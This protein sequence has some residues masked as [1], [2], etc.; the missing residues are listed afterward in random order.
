[1]NLKQCKSYCNYLI[2]GLCSDDLAYRLQNVIP[3][4]NFETRKDNLLKSEFVDE[5][6]EVSW[7]NVSRKKCFE[8]L[9]F[10]VCFIGSE[11]GIQ[12][13]EDLAYF[14]T[15]G[16][17][18]VSLQSERFSLST[19][20][21]EFCLELAK[22]D[23]DIVLWGTGTYF[24]AY[25]RELGNKY[26]PAYAV[27]SNSDRWNTMKEGIPIY[28]P[29]KLTEKTSR[30][31]FVIIC[32]KNYV[33]IRQ[34]LLEIGRIDYRTLFFNNDISLMDEYIVMLEEEKAYMQEAHR[35]LMILLKEFDRVCRKYNLKYFM[36][37]GSLIGA[38]RHRALIPWDDDVDVAMFRKD[39]DSLLRH[40]HEEWD[41]REFEYVNY[42]ELGDNLF[43]DFM[44]RLVYK[45]ISL[46]NDIYAKSEPKLRKDLINKLN[47]DIYVLDNASDNI[48]YHN[49]QMLKIRALYG[50]A[51]GHRVIFD[52]SN[53]NG[54]KKSVRI[55]IKCLSTVGKIIPLK[56]IYHEFEKTRKKYNKKETKCCFESNGFITNIHWRYDKSLLGNGTY[57]KVYGEDIMVPEDYGGYLE[58]HGYHN[59]MQ[60]PPANV[61]KPTHSTRS[62]W[63]MWAME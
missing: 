18:V 10:D 62:P 5:V 16:V 17:R 9:G 34:R 2:V 45:G 21:L 25:M 59:Y 7:D 31:H 56:W 15:H 14:R 28:S 33:P 47:L 8:Q 55:Y 29:E 1:M 39:Y 6:I 54:Q 41:G 26:T 20:A 12:Y 42:D 32:A 35:I 61:R 23:R 52:L 53:Y 27:D 4:A 36:N 30:P 44:S 24:E 57:L 60:Y 46:P 13:I 40:V 58:A 19:K 11:Y 3:Q 37:C 22:L 38:V 63:I 43:H 50:L 51:M 48:K 49:R